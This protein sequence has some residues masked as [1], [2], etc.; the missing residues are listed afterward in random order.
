[1][2]ELKDRVTKLSPEQRRRLRQKLEERKAAA[3]GA[4]RNAPLP[5]SY[6]Q[7]GLWLIT[8]LDPQHA[9]YKIIR[10]LQFSG[11]LDKE[12]L[13]W[14]INQ[15]IERHD[16]LRTVFVETGDQPLQRVLPELDIELAELNLENQPDAQQQQRI[17][18]RIDHEATY[19]FDLKT[20]PLTGQSTRPQS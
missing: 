20:G 11:P 5:L 1:M 3:S 14:A 17:E 19:R 4:D 9:Q 13:A 15:I 10:K 7:H 16:S 18:R 8:Q 6:S 12:R 2:D